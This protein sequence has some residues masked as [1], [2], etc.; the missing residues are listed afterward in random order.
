MIRPGNG[1]SVPV[2]VHFGKAAGI[3]FNGP[4]PG[5]RGVRRMLIRTG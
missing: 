1:G 2:D 3:T 5:R 4:W